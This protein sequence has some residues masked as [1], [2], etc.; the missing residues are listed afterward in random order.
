MPADWRTEVVEKTKV[1]D[2]ARSRDA[3]V[4]DPLYREIA[5]AYG[6]TELYIAKSDGFVWQ[7]QKIDSDDGAGQDASIALAPDGK[8]HIAYQDSAAYQLRH[9]YQSDASWI[10]EVVDENE[11]T[12]FSTDV[13]ADAEG[14]I[15]ITYASKVDEDDYDLHLAV[16]S[17]GS[18][19]TEQVAT[20][21]NAG[22]FNDLEIDSAG[23]LHLAFTSETS[24]DLLYYTR[25]AGLWQ[26]ETVDTGSLGAE[27]PS[28]V[29]DEDDYPHIAY[30]DNFGQ[31]LEYATKTALGWSLETAYSI[32]NVGNYA[33][34]DL[35]SYQFARIAHQNADTGSL[36]YSRETLYGWVHEKVVAGPDTG[37]Y[38]SMVVQ[39]GTSPS[40][41][42]R[43]NQN[44]PSLIYRIRDAGGWTVTNIDQSTLL[45]QLVDMAGDD[46]G[47]PRLAYLKRTDNFRLNVAK[48]TAGGWEKR[49][50]A[51]TGG[52][53]MKPA[54]SIESAGFS[55]LLYMASDTDA[56]TLRHSYQNQTGW[57]TED[58]S[59]SIQC[60]PVDST[61]DSADVMRVVCQDE[62][63]GQ[64]RYAEYFSGSWN[65][66]T[67]VDDPKAGIALALDIDSDDLVHLAYQQADDLDLMYMVQAGGSWT[68]ELIEST[69]ATGYYPDLILD[70][71][72]RPYVSYYSAE[73]PASIRVARKTAS[74]WEIE[75]VEEVNQL[76]LGTGISLDA[77]QYPHLVYQKGDVLDLRYAYKDGGGWHISTLD[78]LGNTGLY[79]SLHLLE[80]V[81][82]SSERFVFYSS[83]SSGSLEMAVDCVIESDFLIDNTD[84]CESEEVAFTADAKG[85]IS[86]YHWTFGDG[87]TSTAVN[88]THTYSV[89]GNY[90]VTLTVL[91]PCGLD[92][93]VKSEVI[94][95]HEEPRT[96]FEATPV[97]VHAGDDV[98]FTDLSTGE[99][100]SYDWSFGDGLSSSFQ[101]PTH[102]YNHIGTYSVQL[103]TEGYCGSDSEIKTDYI[104]VDCPPPVADFIADPMAGGVPLLVN[105]SDTSIEHG[106]CPIYDWQWNFGDGSTSTE[107]NPAHTYETAG[108]KTVQLT[109]IGPGGTDTET[110]VHYIAVGCSLPTAGFY[111]F[112]VMGLSPLRVHFYDSSPLDPLCPIISREWTFGDGKTSGEEDP[113]NTYDLP[114]TYSV[115]LKVTNA[116]G[117]DIHTKGNYIYAECPPPIGNFNVSTTQGKAPLAV[118]FTD[119]SS[120]WPGCPLTSWEWFFGDGGTASGP[121]ATHVYNGV[122]IFTVR[123]VVT[124]TGGATVVKKQDLI[125]V[126][127]PL[128]NL[129]FEADPTSGTP[130]LTV[131][132]D[133]TTSSLTGCV[134][135]NFY[136]NFG[137]GET[138]FNHEPIHVYQTEGLYDVTYSACNNS[139]CSELTR[140]D[141]I[142]AECE[143]PLAEFSADITAGIL[144]L[145]VQFT[146]EAVTTA[147]C[148]TT[149]WV[150]D[151]GDGTQS[152][153]KNPIHIYN[154][155]GDYSVSLTAFNAA[156][157]NNI[158]K[159][160][161]IHI[162]SPA[163]ADFIGLPTSGPSPLQVSFQNTSRGTVDTFEWDFGDGESTAIENPI[164][165]YVMP[166]VY[167]VSLTA[168][169]LGG[170]NTEVKTDYIVV[171]TPSAAEFS[172]DPIV[173]VS[174]LLVS[175]TDE[176]TGDIDTWAWDFGD[177]DVSGLRHPDHVYTDPGIYTVSLAVDGLGG[178]SQA[179]KTDLIVVYQG[180]V[181][182]YYAAPL[183]GPA[184]WYV[185][186]YNESIGDWDTLF[187]D[188]GDG[189]TSNSK[190]PSHTYT[191]P[192]VYTTSLTASGP[193]G[194]NTRVRE[195]YI[196]IYT[197]VAAGYRANL[198]NGPVPLTVNFTDES[199][200]D[201]SNWLWDFGDGQTSNVRNPTYVYTEPGVYDVLL[202]TSGPGGTDAEM[203]FD[204]IVATCGLPQ[205]AFEASTL[206]GLP[207]L[208]VTFDNQSTAAGDCINSYLWNF[209]DGGTS[210]E[211]NP[212]HQYQTP[213]TYTVSL[214]VQGPGGNDMETR[215]DYIHVVCPEPTTKFQAYPRSGTSPL[216]VFF[217]EE[218]K[219]TSGCPIE[220]YLWDFG[221][222]ATSEERNPFK[223][224]EQPGFFDVS[225]K[226][227][228]PDGEAQALEP[229]YVMVYCAP[230]VAAFSADRTW[231][232]GPLGI[233]FEDLSTSGPGCELLSWSWSFGDG[234]SSTQQNPYHLYESAGNFTVALS[235]NSIGGTDVVVREDYARILCG[236]PVVDF[237]ATPTRGQPPLSVQFTDQTDTIDG[238]PVIEYQ[239]DFGDGNGS[240]EASPV[241]EYSFSGVYTVQLEVVT[242]GGNDAKIVENMITVSPDD[243]DDDDYHDDDVAPDDD[244]DNGDDDIADDDTASDDDSDDDDA[245]ADDSKEY[246]TGGPGCI[247]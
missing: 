183:A 178:P 187:W 34:L 93:M 82:G 151:F 42:Y 241:H 218:V 112:P 134:P 176:S 83:K 89:P 202:T 15:Y 132:F 117:Y 198:T 54:L 215:E 106:D 24:G 87:V 120:T 49:E 119:A 52:Y 213:G 162:Y 107:R 139:G 113:F 155:A 47:Y 145:A 143:P 237:S 243:D 97:N 148:G 77:D 173:G 203:K 204:F 210:S 177:G 44:Q 188:F 146:E 217:T 169:G 214:V 14:R 18:W 80:N 55:H 172:A 99:I 28:L 8:L 131:A 196:T 111:G 98:V 81:D 245:Q 239:W 142:H 207:T 118:A 16:K 30:H 25:S 231:G 121:N 225:L 38:P 79:P 246:S 64:L 233:Q 205:A 236:D 192:G 168:S 78:E 199:T 161:Y 125:R 220:S 149:A 104:T 45:P 68:S 193:G 206:S 84:P 71:A 116:L 244:T 105:F 51:S 7:T 122:G 13:E 140:E 12:G 5:I 242:L 41:S 11:N 21:G 144:P 230:P 189:V 31:T 94:K 223:V 154:T 69:G 115:S 212:V 76:G 96:Q 123:M 127:C 228:Y 37:N 101:N 73:A 109:V 163:D 166:G 175:F 4:Y 135:F 133:D 110:K 3:M 226:V 185:Q 53:L 50:V 152:S 108:S 221:D 102:A 160:N 124:S 74:N 57:L 56:L 60:D 234:H 92:L 186:F 170:T 65:F 138:S 171:N 35:D 72:G 88:P 95:V 22:R 39:Q 61:F 190:Y 182:D 63:V 157:F 181:A 9:A 43:S 128:P 156:G 153:E 180:V 194:L 17:A 126:T 19:S 27:Y 33:A 29:I 195:N 147:S 32:G 70:S 86:T 136:W 62:A 90:S 165:A 184:P 238:C 197:P 150:W 240:Q 219:S 20:V 85:F 46:F 59:A 129:K 137:D 224:Y 6:Q 66:E 200:G 247:L 235:V 130:P 100:D 209:G 10:I 103:T 229:E 2:E 48:R 67:I 141:Y 227:T 201:I 75:T 114:G 91:G 23:A 191:T 167:T 232:E 208:E 222:G 58:V 158:T 159:H 36:I 211:V 1:F 164:H 26:T 40:I 179:I 216:T 174:P